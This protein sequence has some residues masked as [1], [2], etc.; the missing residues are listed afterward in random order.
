MSSKTLHLYLYVALLLILRAQVQISE[1]LL[2]VPKE[3][4]DQEDK[5]KTKTNGL[6]QKEVADVESGSAENGELGMGI[7]FKHPE[8]RR[9][10][11]VMFVNWIVVT[12]GEYI[13][14]LVCPL[15]LRT[16]PVKH[17]VAYT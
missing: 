5:T 12:L 13:F 16:D 10:T 6:D 7:L 15:T 3:T 1:H 8:L 14:F 9:Y 4:E 2:Q 17:S 11:L